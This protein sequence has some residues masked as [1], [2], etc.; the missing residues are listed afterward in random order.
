[1][2]YRAAGSPAVSGDLLRYPDGSSV[3]AWAESAMLWATQNGIISGIDGM[4][5]PQGQATR[6]QVATMLMRFREVV[7]R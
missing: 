7:I 1:M 3:S 4:L 2:L 5:T 6:T